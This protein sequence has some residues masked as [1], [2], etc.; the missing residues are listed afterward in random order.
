MLSSSQRWLFFHEKG[1]RGREEFI[2]NRRISTEKAWTFPGL[3]TSG[4][5]GW[6]LCWADHGALCNQSR[7]SSKHLCWPP[8]ILDSG[9]QLFLTQGGFAE[10]RISAFFHPLAVKENQKTKYKILP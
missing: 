4:S 2:L 10:H 5:P 1:A 9:F 8:L 6:L 7:G 3:S